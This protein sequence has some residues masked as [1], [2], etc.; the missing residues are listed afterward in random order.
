M[1]MMIQHSDLA[2]MVQQVF[3]RIWDQEMGSGDA[4][5]LLEPDTVL[6]TTGLDSSKSAKKYE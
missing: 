1:N 5:P 3:A 2:Q 4:V 6:L